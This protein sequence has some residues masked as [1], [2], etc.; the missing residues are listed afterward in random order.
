M[1]HH[2][3][4][5]LTLAE[6]RL[7]VCWVWLYCDAC[8]HGAPTA[9]TPWMIR[10]DPNA[11]SDLLR[12]NSRCGRCGDRGASVRLPSWGGLDVGL[13]PFPVGHVTKQ[14]ARD[15]AANATRGARP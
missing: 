11:S 15:E 6:L 4:P 14:A 8:G 9:L 12:R 5:P 2:P 10:F 1:R 7:A 3:T 13:A